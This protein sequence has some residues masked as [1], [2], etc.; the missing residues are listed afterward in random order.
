MTREEFIARREEFIARWCRNSGMTWEEVQELNMDAYP[1]HCGEDGCRGWQMYGRDL[2][3]LRIKHG[4][5][6]QEQEK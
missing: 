6:R 2:M 1:C 3:E 4:L 5:E